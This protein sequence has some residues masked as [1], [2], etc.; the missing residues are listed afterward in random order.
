MALQI[1]LTYKGAETIHEFSPERLLIGRLTRAD[2]PGLDL[3]VDP[4]V[5]RHHAVLEMKGDECW[6]TDIGSRYGTLINGRDIRGAGPC[7]L[8]GDETIVIGETQLQVRWDVR[9]AAGECEAVIETDAPGRPLHILEAV[10]AGATV[11]I[12]KAALET[13]REQRLA[14]LSDLPLQFARQTSLEALLETVVRRVVELAPAAR[15]GAVLLR[16]GEQNGLLLKAYVSEKEPAVST[17]LAQRAIN[18]RRAFVWRREA[19]ADPSLSMRRLEIETGVYVPLLW[20]DRALGVLC[21]DTPEPGAA[22][23]AEDLRLVMSVAQYAA[24]A[25]ANYQLQNE[26]R[27]N[28]RL[29]ERLLTNFSPKLRTVLMDRARQGRLRPGGEHSEVALLLCDLCGFTATSAAM[30][31][32]DVVEMVNDY[33]HTLAEALFAHDGTI[34]KYIGDAVLAVFGSP[35]PDPRHC[36]KAVRAA[37]EM[38]RRVA[39]VNTRRTGRG[40]PTCRVAIGVHCG[41]V[42]HGF[43]GTP[44]RLEFTVIGDAV[45]RTARYCSFAGADGV[46]LSPEVFQQV[47]HLAETEKQIIRPKEGELTAHRLKSLRH[48]L[49]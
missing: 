46:L 14:A 47:F 12:S 31:T 22:F 13:A 10:E 15:R 44:E 11:E 36:E 28:A 30:E 42:F 40:E 16:R 49:G 1:T 9:K 8:S 17:T 38:Q 19:E 37:V 34:D 7:R 33:L 18:E 21:L 20:Q 43:I 24:A 4:C 39:E 5:S 35:E 2:G 3:S 23:E 6:L 25:V 26:L 41:I 45:N 27:Q 48:E 29:L 32:A